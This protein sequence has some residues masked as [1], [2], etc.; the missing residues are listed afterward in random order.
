MSMECSRAIGASEVAVSPD[1]EAK[2]EALVR[3]MQAVAGELKAAS[4]EIRQAV[5]WRLEDEVLVASDQVQESLAQF[6][7]GEGSV[8]VEKGSAPD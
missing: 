5:Q 4:P 7:R 3:A 6:R 1:D 8:L 2:V